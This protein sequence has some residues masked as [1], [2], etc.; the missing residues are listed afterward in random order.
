MIECNY[1]NN[2]NKDCGHKNNNLV[3]TEKLNTGGCME[4]TVVKF[5]AKKAIHPMFLETGIIPIE[6]LLADDSDDRENDEKVDT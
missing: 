2:K 1:T 4:K 6:M 5:D 3:A